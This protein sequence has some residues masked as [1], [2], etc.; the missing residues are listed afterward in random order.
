LIT[1]GKKGLFEELEKTNEENNKNGN[2]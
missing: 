1:K 2:W